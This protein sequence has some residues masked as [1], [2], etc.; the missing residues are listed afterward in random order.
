VAP[1]IFKK[2]DDLR[3]DQLCMQM[4]A[5]MDRLLKK[6]S[7]DLRLTAYRVLAT[8]SDHGMVEFV[9]RS[10]TV[11]DVLQ[12]HKTLMAFFALHNPDPAGPYGIAASALETFT[13]SCAGFCVITYLLGVGDRHLDNLMVTED[14][15]LIHIDFGFIMGR[16]PKPFPPP[17]KLCKEMVEGMGGTGSEHY[18]RFKT[19]CCEAYNIL[20][21]STTLILNMFALMARASIP[22]V[23]GDPEKALL[24]LESKFRLDLDDEAAV[25]HMQALITDSA[26]A[27]FQQ[28]FEVTH[29]VATYLR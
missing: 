26:S 13:K 11:N 3:Q 29:R 27:L 1:L 9:P 22:D 25:Q 21:K 18:A 10:S 7:L 4:V 20:R 16:D 24:K 23:S 12:K 19:Y 6:E 15:R 28:V 2:G 17:M 14:A 5:L 8:G